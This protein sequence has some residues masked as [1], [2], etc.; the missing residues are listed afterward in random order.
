MTLDLEAVPVAL[1]VRQQPVDDQGEGDDAPHPAGRG[2]GRRR[3]A[4]VDSCRPAQGQGRSCTTWSPNAIKF[5]NEGGQVTVHAVRR[6]ARGRRPAVRG[7]GPDEA[8][9]W[10]TA[11]SRNS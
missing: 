11:H 2:S 9:R 6:P 5:T 4:R 1:V 3:G 8:F 7:L 10:P